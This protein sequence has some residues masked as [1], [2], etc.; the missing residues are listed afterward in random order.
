MYDSLTIRASEDALK[1]VLYLSGRIDAQ[2]ANNLRDACTQLR[3]AGTLNVVISLQ[4][5][6]FVSSTG[7][8]HFLVITEDFK[9]DGGDVVFAEPANSVRHVLKLLNLEQFLTIADTVDAALE[10]QPA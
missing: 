2:G 7:L 5:V 4:D 6:R 10:L 9:A 8:G 3:K 1:P